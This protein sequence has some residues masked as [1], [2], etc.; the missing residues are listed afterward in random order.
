MPAIY[1]VS[2]MLLVKPIKATEDF[3]RFEADLRK[4][5]GWQETLTDDLKYLRHVPLQFGGQF[6]QIKRIDTPHCYN[7]ETDAYTT[8]KNA[9]GNC[10]AHR[11]VTLRWLR[12]PRSPACRSAP[13]T[14]MRIMNPARSGFCT[15]VESCVC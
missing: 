1:A 7:L 11:W 5:G 15:P 13:R 3:K 4:E 2:N 12:W 9:R 10:F 14:I 8:W 6:N